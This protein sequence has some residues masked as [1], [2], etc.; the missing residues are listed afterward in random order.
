MDRPT[1]T[2]REFEKKELTLDARQARDLAASTAASLQLGIT[3]EGNYQLKAGNQV[4]T[5]VLPSLNVLIQP[6]VDIPDLFFLLSYARRL[7]WAAEHFPF[8]H[9]EDLFASLVQFFDAEM[10]RVRIFGLPRDYVE[11]SE[12]LP[13]IRGR[14]DIAEQLRSRQLQ[15]YPLECRFAD[16]TD[17]IPLNRILKEA[18]AVALAIPG[19]SAELSTRIRDRHRRLFATVEPDAMGVDL[20]CDVHFTHLT[21]HWEPAYW[22]ATL[23]LSFRSLRDQEGRT[24]GRAFTVQMD[25]VFERFVEIVVR[26]ELSEAGFEV[27]SQM[28]MPL[29]DQARVVDTNEPLN[30][31][32]MQPDLVIMKNGRAVAVA[33]IKY[34]RTDDI[35]DF[36]QPDVYQLFA[37]CSALGVPRGLLICADQQPHTTQRATLPSFG[38]HIDIDGVG[39]N[40]SLPWRRVLDQAKSGAKV[41]AAMASRAVP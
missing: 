33:D 13:T 9:T 26:E 39:I 30:G 16:Y 28:R 34:K 32:G 6:K 2:L 19:L 25:R 7:R 35:G 29:T 11:V 8:V 31:V 23:L 38:G 22:L 1:I 12:T 17:D 37:Y 14:I 10:E 36:Q 4:G 20:R 40:L 15:P 18:H 21:A 3:A 24:I 41:L 5:V 27:R